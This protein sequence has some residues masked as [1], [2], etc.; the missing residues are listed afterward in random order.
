M[1]DTNIQDKSFRTILIVRNDGI[2]A[3]E[4]SDYCLRKGEL[5]I[6]YLPNGNIIVKS[7]VDGNTPWLECPQVEG[8][9][10]DNLTLTYAFG[11]YAP[12]ASGSFELKTKNK[13]MS[14]V[15]LDAFAQEVYTNLIT[16]Q[17]SARFYATSSASGEVGTTHGSPTATL[18][19]TITGSYKYGAKSAAGAKEQAKITAT[20]ANITYDGKV[21]KEMSPENPNA[22]LSY[23][24][25]LTGDDLIYQDTAKTYTF[26]ATAESGEDANRPLTNLGNFVTTNDGGE[27]CGTKT[28]ADAIGQIPAKTL[29]N[30]SA[31]STK[32][33]GYRK[34][35]MGRTTVANPTVDSAF[36]RGD[37]KADGSQLVLTLSQQASTGTKEVTANPNDTALYYAY[38]T[39]LTAKEPT[40]EYFIANEWKPL[41]GPVLVGK[42][43]PVEGANS[44]TA[45]NYTVYKY[46]PNSGIFEG[47]MRTRINIRA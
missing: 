31:A 27:Y 25:A 9:F 1:A 17:P 43:I 18:D 32:Y 44:Y 37:K 19:L 14:E 46:A 24:L 28:F 2:T 33:S 41:S 22:D 5:G 35:F 42:D 21:V 34:M 7:G 15:M 16:G 47:Q 26:Y 40:F 3:W 36:I 8:V 10:E 20:K 30:N 38:P 12:D 39:D 45:K 6:G 11:K 23:T 29:L 4:E 13:T